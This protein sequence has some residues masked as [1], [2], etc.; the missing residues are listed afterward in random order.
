MSEKRRIAIASNDGENIS[1]HFG[2]TRGFVVYDVDDGTITTHEFRSNT[3]TGHARGLEGAGH[4]H[5]RHGPILAALDDCSVVIS[6]GMGRRIFDDLQHN[7][8][9]VFVTDEGTV[10][11]ALQL[12]LEGNLIDRPEQRCNH[13]H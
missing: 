2:R 4:Q 5:D 6:R 10:E 7:G 8:I 13:H 3:F 1:A 12:Y 9:E 11:K